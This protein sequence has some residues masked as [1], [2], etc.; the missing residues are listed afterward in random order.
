MLGGGGL[1]TISP[2]PAQVLLADTVWTEGS[3]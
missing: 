3:C 2:G 1:A